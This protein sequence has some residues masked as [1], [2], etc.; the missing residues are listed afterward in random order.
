MAAGDIGSEI[1]TLCFETGV[2][3]WPEIIHV[4]GDVYAMVYRSTVAPYGHLQTFTISSTGEIALVGSLDFDTVSQL[5]VRIIHVSGDVYAIAYCGPAMDGWLRTVGIQSDGTII[6]SIASFEFDTTYG[7]NH[8]IIHV[9]GDVYL[10]VYVGSL[11]IGSRGYIRTVRISDDGTTIQSISSKVQ[12][13]TDLRFPEILHVSGDVFAY[14]FRDSDA[15]II[16]TRKIY[17]DGSI[18]ASPEDT[19]IFDVYVNTQTIDLSFI[20]ISGDVFAVAYCG[21]PYINGH[22]WLKTVGVQSDGTIT[23]EINSLEFD[24]DQ[25][26]FPSIVHVANDAYMIAYMGYAG[27]GGRR[28]VYISIEI[29]PGGTI[30]NIIDTK[31]FSAAPIER[32]QDLMYVSGDVYVCAYEAMG[33]DDGWLRTFGVD[34]PAEAARRHRFTG[35][36]QHRALH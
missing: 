25:G 13:S 7:T 1:Q 12:V 21:A 17:S 15:G 23:G 31:I 18:E 10:I 36:I 22:G 16:E 28:G 30:R 35:G 19:F 3:E 6:G 4:A 26:A 33:T 24:T 20:H 32:Y 2:C 34:T 8:A 27:G 14:V 9:S 29:S 5:K 11:G